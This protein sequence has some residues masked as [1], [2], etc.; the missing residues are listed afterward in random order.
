M[1]AQVD[2]TQALRGVDENVH[3]QRVEELV[4]DYDAVNPI[5]QA[6]PDRADLRGMP[7]QHRCRGGPSGL[8]A[9]DQRGA[10]PCIQAWVFRGE[11]VEDVA[12]QPSVASTGFDEVERAVAET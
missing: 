9:F 10:N 11:C 1:A 5:R 2:F 7:A 12:G 4:R 6:D 3:R 8:A